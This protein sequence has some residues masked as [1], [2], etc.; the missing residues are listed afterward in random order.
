M[1]NSII[2][3]L[4]TIVIF[5]LCYISSL[6]IKETMY[7][8][9]NIKNIPCDIG[10][11]NI[12]SY[13]CNK[14]GYSKS[15]LNPFGQSGTIR[16]QDIATIDPSLYIPKT[17]KSLNSPIQTMPDYAIAP[18][19]FE[20]SIYK[21]PIK[22]PNYYNDLSEKEKKNYNTLIANLKDKGINNPHDPKYFNDASITLSNY[23]LN[24]WVNFLRN[25][26]SKPEWLNYYETLSD[27][28]KEL[29]NTFKESL[30]KN[31]IDIK[32]NNK[33]KDNIEP[34]LN[35]LREW[36]NFEIGYDT[37]KPYFLK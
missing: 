35:I 7:I 1:Y 21:K 31:G 6:N 10:C 37:E 15:C 5:I 20:K 9:S 11:H 22:R 14:N 4:M 27:N 36:N 24:E 3:I 16:E 26:G 23:N 18:S 29:Y 8:N 28:E 32:D 33:L 12:G 34:N 17:S 25:T 19:T 30:R 2:I 13:N